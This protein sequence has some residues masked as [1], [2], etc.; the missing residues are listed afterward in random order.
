MK[1]CQILFLSRILPILIALLSIIVSPGMAAKLLAGKSEQH[2]Y[3]PVIM[4][5]FKN[6]YIL[7]GVILDGRTTQPVNGA[8]VCV[9]DGLICD[10]SNSDGEYMLN[11]V[12]S[13]THTITVA[14]PD[15]PVFSDELSVPIDSYLPFNILLMPV[16]EEGQWRVVL[17]WVSTP[18]WGDYPNNLELHLWLRDQEDYHIHEVS[19]LDCENDLEV[20]PF[21]C[22]EIDTQRGSGPDTIVFSEIIG[23]EYTF[24]VLH[25]YNGYPGVPPITDLEAVV[26]V[27]NSSGLQDRFLIEDVQDEVGDLWYIF[28]LINGKIERQNCLQQYDIN[29]APPTPCN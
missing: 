5:L 12:P 25:F 22:Y 29:E 1:K 13:G 8:E 24:A 11:K 20:F 28:D 19:E 2:V 10:Q 23:D 3:L 26:E 9:M 7:Q 15:Y 18:T 4:K 21:A 16:L 17:T 14:H 27:Y 6:E